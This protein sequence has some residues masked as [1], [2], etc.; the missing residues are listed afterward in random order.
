MAMLH[1]TSG[2]AKGQNF[3]LDQNNLMMIGRDSSCTFQI[4]D[5]ELSRM[6]MQV[7]FV[8][9][10]DRHYAIDFDSKNGVWINNVKMDRESP[11]SDGDVL[12]LGDT[13]I[14]YCV[15][16]AVDAQH[17]GSIAKIF[18]QRGDQTI[19]QDD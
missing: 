14:L 11:L 7:K 13:T 18:G 12:K 16:D 2:P 19:T 17:A 8:T 15:D 3:A 9:G 6:H 1:V 4:I 5:T 10:E